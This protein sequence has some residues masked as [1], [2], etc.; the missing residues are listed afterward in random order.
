VL[1]RALIL[2]ATATVSAASRTIAAENRESASDRFET[3]L[4]TLTAACA[5][6]P[7]HTSR[8]PLD[9]ATED[10]INALSR[11][12][13]TLEA[14]ALQN[15]V[16][17]RI[18]ELLQR[19]CSAC[20]ELEVAYEQV[21]S[22]AAWLAAYTSSL[23]ASAFDQA[24]GRAQIASGIDRVLKVNDRLRLAIKPYMPKWL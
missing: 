5:P 11:Q 24:E 1:A 2:T 12:P 7:P 21:F 14:Q 19:L 18:P 17:S 10:V 15:I 4:A 22:E 8:L 9:S 23:P 16:R 20:K 13:A 3:A 6:L